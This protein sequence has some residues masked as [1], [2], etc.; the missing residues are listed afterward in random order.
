MRHMKENRK[1]IQRFLDTHKA[2]H[3]LVSISG[4][5]DS[6][7]LIQ[8]AID[9]Y[10]KEKIVL[11]HAVIDIDWDETIPTCKAQAEFFDLPLVFTQAQDKTGKK[12][13]ILDVLVRPKKSKGVEVENMWP[14]MDCRWCTAAFKR[15]AMNKVITKYKGIVHV[16]QGER[17]EESEDRA[18]LPDFE[19]C[20]RTSTKTRTVFR[21]HPIKP[22]SERE[23][24]AVINENGIPKHP[25]YDL[26]CSRASCAVCVFSSDKEIAIAGKHAPHIVA[27]M[28][29]AERKISTTF[30]YK[31]ATKTRPAMKITIEDILRKE[32][33]FDAV[34]KLLA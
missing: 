17:A 34:E 1:E 6:C 8:Y 23:V 25:A 21:T 3:V 16:L 28:I 5:K 19:M 11:M 32:N 12:I 24:W 33:A 2:D 13:G 7:A 30:R 31:P 18:N 26:G 9:N 15:D 27:K 29:K 14:S 20:D 22:C 10:P 4:G